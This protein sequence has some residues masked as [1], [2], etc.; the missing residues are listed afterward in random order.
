[1]ARSALVLALAALLILGAAAG[2]SGNKNSG[3]S[4]SS[5]SDKGGKAA[6]NAGAK[7]LRP[8]SVCAATKD[9]AKSYSSCATFREELCLTVQSESC[10]MCDFLKAD[11]GCDLQDALEVQTSIDESID[12]AEDDIFQQVFGNIVQG[13][14]TVSS[15][16]CATTGPVIVPETASGSCAIVGATTVVTYTC[17]PNTIPTGVGC[18]DGSLNVVEGS[19]PGVQLQTAQCIY[20]SNTATGVIMTVTCMPS[21]EVVVATAKTTRK[22][23]ANKVAE[24]QKALLAGWKIT[25]APGAKNA[26]AKK[27]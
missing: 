5:G 3:S 8:A 9:A 13:G 23:V 19:T 17:P 2:D 6:A 22:P 10:D 25:A 7:M 1:M 20:P 11:D 27:P 14:A 18:N 24:R 16:N 21:A 12:A 26:A 15:A 4:K